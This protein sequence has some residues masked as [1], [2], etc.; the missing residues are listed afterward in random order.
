MSKLGSMV[1][2]LLTT[3]WEHKYAVS[4]RRMIMIHIGNKPQN[5]KEDIIM[6]AIR[7]IKSSNSKEEAMQQILA[8]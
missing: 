6:Q 1:A 5:T 8:L 3:L 7:I 4:E 2:N